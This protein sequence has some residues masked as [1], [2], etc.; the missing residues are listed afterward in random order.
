MQ[1]VGGRGA[2]A[3]G[4]SGAKGRPTRA[5]GSRRATRKR[6]RSGRPRLKSKRAGQAHACAVGFVARPQRSCCRC[7]G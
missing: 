4:G 5:G 7:L 6:R 2:V 3:A 1:G